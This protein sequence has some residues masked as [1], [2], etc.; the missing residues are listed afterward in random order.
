MRPRPLVGLLCALCVL[1]SGTVA[2]AVPRLGRAVIVDM[3]G[4]ATY[5][6]P[7]GVFPLEPAMALTHA[8][9]LTTDR[10]SGVCSVL[11]PGAVLCIDENTRLRFDVLEHMPESGLPTAATEAHTL[12]RI[13]LAMERGAILLNGGEPGSGAAIEIALG[14]AATVRTRGGR[15][16]I[17][18]RGGAWQVHAEQGDLQ[19]DSQA[20]HTVIKEGSTLV[21][22]PTRNGTSSGL[23]IESNGADGAP[24]YEF[25]TCREYFRTLQPLAFD[26]RWN[27]IDQ[28]QSWI[29]GDTP[30]SFIGNP[31]DWEDVSPT[32]RTRRGP[33][34]QSAPP[35][36]PAVADGGARR[37]WEMWEWHQA[38]GEMR[39][40]NY[41]P[42]TAVN[43]TEMWQGETFD[44]ET[45]K[46]ELHWASDYGYNSLRVFVQYAVWKEYPKGLKDRMKTFLD[47]ASDNELETVF[48]LF[49]DTQVAGKD[50]HTGPQPDAIPGRHNSQWT[51]SP[52]HSLVAESGGAWKSLE[53][54]VTDIVETFKDDDRV[55]M[56]DLY[57]RPG[58]GGMG[59]QSLPLVKAAFEWARSAQPSQPLTAGV[60]LDLGSEAVGEIVKRSDVLSF[61]AYEG[62]SDVES[63]LLL[64]E[65]S[66]RPVVCTGWLRRGR[67]NTFKDVLPIFAEHDVGWYHW[68]LVAGRTQMYLPSDHPAGEPD[69]QAWEQDILRPDG[70]PYDEEEIKLIRAFGFSSLQGRTP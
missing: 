26:W 12:N 49:D 33:E 55:V 46:T 13:A 40:I 57:N 20:D 14:S 5:E 25:H 18:L 11:T 30:I 65:V 29:E 69:P 4:T 48:V 56:W 24:A 53:H 58:A 32:R 28:L 61:N 23:V 27:G 10:D 21:A 16:T 34:A 51:P 6:S 15:C 43:T 68:G 64:A 7:H 54:Y 2:D 8:L 70:T 67:G 59:L 45:I 63:R 3:R 19:L 38:K 35:A 62:A 37:R 47:I 9:T 66:A 22:R 17:G 41:I 36:P 52:G 31:T 39:G 50:P 1:G 60:E 42:H 44:P